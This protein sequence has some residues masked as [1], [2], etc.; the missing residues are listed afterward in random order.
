MSALIKKNQKVISKFTPARNKGTI[1][2][3]TPNFCENIQE[4]AN[5]Y[6]N[7]GCQVSRYS[8][9]KTRNQKEKISIVNLLVFFMHAER[10][11]R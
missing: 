4:Y 7:L 2:V 3:K 6:M 8:K 5:A 10:T 1:L 11:Y 9:H